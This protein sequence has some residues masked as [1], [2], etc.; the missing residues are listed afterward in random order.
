ME[1]PDLH[2]LRAQALI[3]EL[4]EERVTE[5]HSHL[6]RVAEQARSPF[7]L[8]LLANASFRLLRGVLRHRFAPSDFDRETFIYQVR[9]WTIEAVKAYRRENTGATGYA[10]SLMLAINV[11]DFL[12]EGETVSKFQAELKS[13]EQKENAVS[14]P[15]ASLDELSE[16]EERGEISTAER[17]Y[18][19]A[20]HFESN[21]PKE[22]AVTKLWAALEVTTDESECE[23]IADKLVSLLISS[24]DLEGVEKVLSRVTDLR[25]GLR[26]DNC[27]IDSAG[28]KKPSRSAR[29]LVL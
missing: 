8:R 26:P 23:L 3:Q 24:E 2:L 9:N 27:V 28:Q 16:L 18:R 14:G 19:E 22:R 17:L 25:S 5:A 29:L 6:N 4:T 10:R 7:L 13:L 11:F 21:G 20:I 1:D 15:V 12:D